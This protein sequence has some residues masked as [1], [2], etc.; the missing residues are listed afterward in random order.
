M[1]YTTWIIVLKTENRFIGHIV[2]KGYP[3]ENGEVTIGYWMQDKYKRNEYMF[4]ALKVVI[5]WIFLNSD[6][7]FVIADT[8]KNNIP[9]QKLLH[10]FYT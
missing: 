10:T 7:K 9:S 3:N 5:P 2:L 1:W 6:A 8:L 4:E